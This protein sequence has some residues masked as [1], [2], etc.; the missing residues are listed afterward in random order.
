MRISPFTS[1]LFA[2]CAI[3]ACAGCT[4]APGYPLRPDKDLD[5]QSLYRDNCSGC[6]GENG[7]NGAAIA[8]NN[9]AYLAIAGVDHVRTATADGVNATLMPGFAR[10]AGG[11]LTDEQIEA[12]VQG[13]V[14]TWARPSEFNGIALP[15]YSSNTPGNAS[16]GEKSYAHACAWCHG[17]D[18]TGLQNASQKGGSRHSIVD[19]SYLAL[20]SDQ[21]LR[22]IIVAGH[23]D[24][25]AHDWRSYITSPSARPL[26]AQ[27]IN[28]IVAWV[29]QHREPGNQQSMSITRGKPAGVAGK[30][31]K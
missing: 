21:S 16:D 1:A 6:H 23:P 9:P 25:N 2:L 4:H 7:R 11:M 24:K 20:V 27:E 31:A 22:S 30:E 18:G 14:H 10:S 19:P 29:A 8:L 15:P 3:L 13:M 5:F 17:A 28:D 26:T 12:L